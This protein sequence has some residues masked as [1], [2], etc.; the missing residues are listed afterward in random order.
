ME[1]VFKKG[2]V[3]SIKSNKDEEDMDGKKLFEAYLFMLVSGVKE[4]TDD[5]GNT[6]KRKDD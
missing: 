2:K 1:V 5:E 3:S 4:F 6:Y